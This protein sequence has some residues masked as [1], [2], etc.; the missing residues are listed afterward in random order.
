MVSFVQEDFHGAEGVLASCRTV[1]CL[2]GHGSG[3]S[4]A[5]K[6]LA[7]SLRGRLQEE[8]KVSHDKTL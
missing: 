4:F 7:M 6:I 8:W 1:T 2:L 3:T 5:A